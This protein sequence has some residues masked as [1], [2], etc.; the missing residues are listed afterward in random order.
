MNGYKIIASVGDIEEKRE[1]A[2]KIRVVTMR[3]ERNIWFPRSQTEIKN[4]FVWAKDWIVDSKGREY[5]PIITTDLK[6]AA[7]YEEAA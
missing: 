1:K 3:G 6:I 4:G 5:S 7:M 2:I